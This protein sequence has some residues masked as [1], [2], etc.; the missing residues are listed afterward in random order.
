MHEKS[1]SFS[2][3][4]GF[5]LAAAGSAVG[6]GNLWRFPYLTAKDGGGLFLLI[7]LILVMTFGYVLLSSDLAIGRRTQKNS[8]R[9]YQS[10]NSRWWFLGILTFLVPVLIM[11]YYAVIGGWILKYAV[12]FLTGQGGAA[13]A[14]AYFVSFITN[15][16]D[17]G[18]Y[19]VL[20]M[21]LTAVIVYRGV[22]KGIEKCSRVMMPILLVSIVLIAGYSLSLSYTDAEGV[23]RTG[24]QGLGVYMMPDFANLTLGKFLQI[25]L[26]A[27]SQIFFSLSVS[28]GIMITYGCYVRKDVNLNQSVSQICLFDTFVGLLAGMM[29]IPSIFVFSGMEGM[30]AGPKLMFVSLP[31]VFASMGA[32]GPFIGMAFFIMAGFAAL[33]SCI[34]VLE[35]I[36]ANCM[37]IFRARRETVTRVLGVLY[38]VIS[39]VI[40]LGYS[41]FY[42]E[43]G[44]PNG[45]TGQLLDIMDYISNS[46]MMPVISLC[47]AILIGWVV[48][49]EWVMEEME[50]DGSVM[51]RKWLYRFIIRYVAPVIMLILCLQAFGILL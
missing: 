1:S 3:Q 4:L 26:D 6:V 51:P 19:A 12:A 5:V 30:A 49:P 37:E 9:A 24:I 40:A 32:V 33:T 20:F 29:I 42:L 38:T 39:V 17:A 10:M 46:C 45:T 22:E 34:S 14:D 36:T 16:W 44:L 2:G 47:S 41:V 35:A 43:V 21:L 15:P 25:L 23:T 11:T 48:K 18:L 28:M 50:R 8:I 31:K 7:Y 27:M 13:A